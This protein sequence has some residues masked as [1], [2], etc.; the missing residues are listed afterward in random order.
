[1][2]QYPLWRY[3]LLVTIIVLGVIYALP[4]IYPQDPSLQISDRRGQSIEELTKTSVETILAENN[5]TPKSVES[6]DKLI[7][8]RFVD[9]PSRRKAAELVTEKL[10]SDFVVAFSLASSSP[11]WLSR[12]GGEPM[13]MGRAVSG[14]VHF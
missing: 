4:N 6:T 12:V 13:Y 11:S 8:V 9:S 10:G 14:G 1:M 5:L 2:N 7:V 3:V